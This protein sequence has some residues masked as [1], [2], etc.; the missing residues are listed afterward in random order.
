MGRM[1]LRW[2]MAIVVG[3][4]ALAGFGQQAPD[5]AAT[6]LRVQ[7]RLLPELVR[8]PH[9]TCVQTITRRYY[10][11]PSGHAASCAGLIAAH[12]K[13]RDKDKDELPLRAWDRLRLEVAIAEGKNVFSW[14]GAPRFEE[15]NFE[16]LAGRGP[17]ASGD[18]GTFLDSV[19]HRASVKFQGE[20]AVKGRRLLEYAYDMPLARSGYLVKTSA[21]WTPTA[22]SGTFLLDPDAADM[23]HLTVRTAELPESNPAC[24]AIS[25]VEYGRTTIHDLAVLI[26][27]ETRLRTIDREGSETLSLTAYEKCREYASKSRML[28]EAPP[29]GAATAAPQTKLPS[30]LSP[31]LRFECRIVTPIDSDTAAAGDPIEALLRSPIHDKKN[32]VLVPAGA[33]IHGRLMRFE[34]R[35]GAFESFRVLVD[36][37]SIEVNGKAVPLRAVPEAMPPAVPVLV[38]FDEGSPEVRS[39]AFHKE[40]LLLQHLDWRW[41]TVSAL[42][43]SEQ[44]A[45][46]TP[47]GVRESMTPPHTIDV[48][49]REF[50]IEASSGVHFKFTVPAGATSVRLEG[51]FSAT[52][53]GSNDVE[54]ALFSNDEFVNSQAQQPAK[55]LYDSGRTTQ[56]TLNVLLPADAATYYL[57][58]S[59]NFPLSTPKVVQASIRL[60]YSL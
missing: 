33:R 7:E 36:L 22:Y 60:H 52:G 19:F 32:G 50:T 20:K 28:L 6:F 30:A 21:G 44:N 23:V 35:S 42:A 57:V 17:L 18:F 59:N 34:H 43:S 14:I 2:A 24:Q 5:P 40:H 27:R 12:D 47:L 46:S 13:R 9:Y 48:A 54:V 15:N 53:G 49:D 58:F 31:G 1:R 25:E 56:G 41:I 4:S 39:F 10:R 29:V 3:C 45:S 38:V 8:L 16:E 51:S 37:D 55:S 11:P 26:P